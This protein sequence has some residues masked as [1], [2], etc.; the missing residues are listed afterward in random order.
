M[1]VLSRQYAYGRDGGAQ[2]V[3]GRHV[4]A[5]NLGVNPRL[6]RCKLMGR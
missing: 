5:A 6:F 4:M 3:W 2:V 1:C